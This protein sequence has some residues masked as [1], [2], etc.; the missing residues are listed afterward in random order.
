MKKMIEQRANNFLSKSKIVKPPVDL[1]KILVDNQVL[2]F[3]RDLNNVAGNTLSGFI[4]KDEDGSLKIF[5][6]S[7]HANTR[8]SFTVAHEL[9]HFALGHLEGKKRVISYRDSNALY[10]E[11]ERE[12]DYFATCLLMPREFLEKYAA[13]HMLPTLSEFAKEFKVSRAAMSK[14][15]NELKIGYYGF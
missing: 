9:G 12:A 13:E 10:N 5:V 2:L 3:E 1:K 4:Q 6:N 11:K 8:N 15:L 7:K 14:R